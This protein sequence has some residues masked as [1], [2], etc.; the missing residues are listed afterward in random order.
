[1][2]EYIRMCVCVCVKCL[3]KSWVAQIIIVV[4]NC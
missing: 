4:T 2:N 1:M 3:E